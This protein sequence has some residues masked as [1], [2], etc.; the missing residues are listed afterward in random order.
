[1]QPAKPVSIPAQF[2][3]ALAANRLEVCG[4]ESGRLQDSV[5]LPGEIFTQVISF[6]YIQFAFTRRSHTAHLRVAVARQRPSEAQRQRGEPRSTS[7]RAK[8]PRGR[9]DSRFT[10]D[11]VAA[12][13]R[14]RRRRAAP[15]TR[16]TRPPQ[17]RRA[18]PQ[19]ADARNRALTAPPPASRRDKKVT[20]ET[21]ATTA[22]PSASRLR[23]LTD[24]TNIEKNAQQAK[25]SDA[26]AQGV[27]TATTAFPALLRRR[28]DAARDADQ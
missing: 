26:R 1:M 24:V 25:P 27:A 15:T 23:A 28:R 13:N 5:P 14:E 12:A 9:R 20:E 19:R 3:C 21:M 6:G 22:T 18:T 11:D 17:Q 10:L 16:T 8:R 2:A 4:Q 7:R